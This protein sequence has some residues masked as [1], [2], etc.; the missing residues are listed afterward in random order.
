MHARQSV[1][2]LRETDPAGNPEKSSTSRA[3]FAPALF[4]AAGF[5]D[6]LVATA[7][8]PAAADF[9]DA[10]FFANF[11]AT[12]FLL[13][14]AAFFDAFD[15]AAFLPAVFFTFDAA[16]AFAFATGLAF[17]AADFDLLLVAAI[18]AN[19]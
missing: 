9:F 19:G 17:L 11:V 18:I 5:F 15:A 12:L 2:S 16:T 6:A 13:D 14:A 7:F 8:L 1:T 10:A 4:D 3:C